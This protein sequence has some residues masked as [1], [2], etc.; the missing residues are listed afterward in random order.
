M[1]FKCI[2]IVSA[3][4]LILSISAISAADLNET[5]HQTLNVDNS[6]SIST[7]VNV[8][9]SD[10]ETMCPGTFED[11]QKEVDNAPAKSVL[12]LYKD[13]YGEDGAKIQ[14][15]KDLVIDGHGH[16]IDCI[17]KCFAFY[18]TKGWITL[19]NI[20]I[21]NGH[22]NGN[23]GAICADGTSRYI[24]ENCTFLNNWAK[25]LGGAIYARKITTIENSTFNKNIAKN[26]GGAL[27]D[28]ENVIIL[29]SKFNQNQATDS[30]GGTIY[31]QKYVLISDSIITNSHS[32]W[33]GGAIYSK[34]SV[35]LLNCQLSNNNAN[36]NNRECR[37]GA[38]RAVKE[39]IIINSTLIGNYA[40]T[41]G[42]A[43]Y[44]QTVRVDSISNMV[45]GKSV[46][47]GNRADYIGG[48]IYS[49]GNTYLNNTILTSNIAYEDGG[50]IHCG[51]AEVRKSTLSY[52]KAEDGSGGAIDADHNVK[53]DD[54]TFC[55]NHAADTA[56]AIYTESITFLSNAMFK[57]NEA[58]YGCGGAIWTCEITNSEV[59]HISFC[60]NSAGFSAGEGLDDD[61]GCY[62]GA[63]F[64]AGEITVTFYQCQFFGNYARDKGGAIYMSDSDSCLSLKDNFFTGNFV[65]TEYSG[66]GSCVYT[67][68]NFD[69]IS[70]NFWNGNDPSSD[71]SQLIEY[72]FLIPNKHHS[73]ENPA[74][75]PPF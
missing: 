3:I 21:I 19:K 40:R 37:G 30:D 16:T 36:G 43:V 10:N 6:T 68:G 41:F 8:D 69:K 64:I 52:N 32:G 73:D 17:G 12:H 51:N 54:C 13:Y 56:G 74:K 14:I 66:E 58:G 50:A 67:C 5:S 15:N 65:P 25:G 45:N 33:S 44:A 70:H 75:S 1:N 39:V 61:S 72:R 18:S 48:A 59:S 35:N 22:S 11:L 9:T 31:S 28:H 34:A 7:N 47:R 60:E 29:K 49:E 20:K 42:G 62:G 71:N 53:I 38:V 2:L 23:G 46:F 63:I 26:Q 4:L 55:G 24:I 57:E 27:Y